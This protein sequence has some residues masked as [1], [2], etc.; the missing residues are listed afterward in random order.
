M[1]TKK[2]DRNFIFQK[3]NFFLPFDILVLSV[4]IAKSLS[5][6]VIFM[7]IR[8]YR[9]VDAVLIIERLK[10]GGKTDIFDWFMI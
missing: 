5:S 1:F 6:S 8:G 2:R 4:F 3:I 10:F 7:T 9:F